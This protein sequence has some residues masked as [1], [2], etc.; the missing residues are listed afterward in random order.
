MAA[1]PEGIR[2]ST[3]GLTAGD[4]SVMVQVNQD[5]AKQISEAIEEGIAQALESIGLAA[6]G[7]AKRA[8]PVDTG[9]LRNS[10]T[11]QLDLG[12]DSVYIGTSVEYGPYVEM[13][14]R[15]TK[16]QPFLRPAATEHGD[17]YRSILRKALGSS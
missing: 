4:I 1:K 6:E 9:R 16:A 2:G 3:K 15:H 11:H 12:D 7:Y 10:I 14:T 17:R 13:G 8:C 5:N